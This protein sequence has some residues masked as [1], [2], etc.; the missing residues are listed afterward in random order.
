[1][2]GNLIDSKIAHADAK[3]SF[4]PSTGDEEL[5]VTDLDIDFT[6]LN[7]SQV[8]NSIAEHFGSGV[9][10]ASG[11]NGAVSTPTSF[12]TTS[13]ATTTATT[14]TTTTTSSASNNTNN[15]NYC[16]DVF[17]AP[18]SSASPMTNTV[19]SFDFDSKTI[20]KPSKSKYFKSTS[21]QCSGPDWLKRVIKSLCIFIPPFIAKKNPLF[22]FKEVTFLLF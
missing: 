1:M 9:A 11:N 20:T 12:S 4:K 3:S 2:S 21:I 14:T 10:G 13:S 15:T 6:Y 17:G 22:F 7:N 8:S 18:P 16:N 5:A 19:P